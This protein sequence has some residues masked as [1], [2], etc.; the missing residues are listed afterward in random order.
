MNRGPTRWQ[1]WLK[2]NGTLV[3]AAPHFLFYMLTHLWI[4]LKPL[5]LLP[6]MAMLAYTQS[7]Y[8]FFIVSLP[9]H[10]LLI[11][12][13]VEAWTKGDSEGITCPGLV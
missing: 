4:S 3:M 9:G 13:M 6:K 10:V 1:P 2:S 11:M 7:G 12:N 5:K 8:V